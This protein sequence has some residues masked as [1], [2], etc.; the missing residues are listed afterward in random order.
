MFDLLG[1][2]PVRGTQRIAELAERVAGRSR[3]QVWQRVSGTLPRLGPT[4]GR[5]YLRARA[6]G[7]VR[8]ETSR[9]AEQDGPHVARLRGEIEAA[10]L[11][12][13]IQAIAAQFHQQRQSAGRRRAA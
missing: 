12:L 3:M 13:L 6:I 8:E 4:E 7:I 10:A 1:L 2:W 11:E 9:L 5:G